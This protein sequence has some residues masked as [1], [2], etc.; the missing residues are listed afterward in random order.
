LVKALYQRKDKRFTRERF[1]KA[2]FIIGIII[3]GGLFS[4]LLTILAN[5]KVEFD[6]FFNG[7]D[8]ESSLID[9]EYINTSFL[10]Q[11]AQEMEQLVGMYHIPYNMTGEGWDYYIPVSVSWS[12]TNSSWKYWNNTQLLA[13]FD[14]LNE[15][16]PHNNKSIMVYTGDR[17]HSALYEGVYCAGEAFRYAW[18]KRNNN[19]GNITAAEERILKIVRAYELLSNVSDKSP[20]VRYAVPNTTLA[21]QKFPGHWGRD[22]HDEVEYKGYKWSLSRR[23][24]RDVS[25][26]IMLGLS[27]AYALVDNETIRTIAGRVIDKSVQYWYDCNWRIIDTDGTSA[28]TGDLISSRPLLEGSVILTFLQMGKLVNP[29][30]WGP[31]YHHYVYDRGLITTIG[32]SMRIGLDLSPKIFDAYYGCNFIFNN[33]PSLILLEED[34]ILREIYL[35]T[36][37]NVLH[38]FTKLHRNANFDVVWLLCHSDMSLSNLY[39]KPKI[40]LKDYDLEIWEKANIK[41]PDNL[42]YIQ[43]FIERDI[44]D[45]LMRYAVRRYPNRD[46]YWAT[47]PGTF[48]NVHQQPIQL[49]TY[50]VPYPEYD[51]WKPTT[52]SAGVINS[53]LTLFGRETTDLGLLNNS[54][55]ADMRKSED[56][57]WTRSSFTVRTTERLTSNPGSFQAP[58]GPDYLSVY[59]MAKYLELI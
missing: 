35:K 44:K 24:S 1:F 29:N 19:I 8:V 3:A 21:Y 18:A 54:L 10:D 7:F 12:W 11:R 9:T 40:N 23:L 2:I 26:G 39:T 6:H 5:L 41:D 50:T 15:S 13:A 37:L 47:A 42:T 48:P 43:E 33:A 4:W 16:D 27:M 25:I 20:F 14:P 53:L 28:T 58:M 34:P 36:W 45:S 38:D 57:M 17:A 49:D 51:Y 52:T 59:W 31:V 32:R 56:I 55:P 30:K 22:D 46:Y